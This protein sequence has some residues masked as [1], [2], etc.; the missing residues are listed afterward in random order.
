MRPR[1]A[2]VSAILAILSALPSAQAAVAANEVTPRLEN[3]HLQDCLKNDCLS[4]VGQTAFIAQGRPAL[5]AIHVQ[6][7]LQRHNSKLLKLKCD[8]F[9]YDV[10]THLL[11][12]D[13]RDVHGESLTIDHNF[14]ITKYP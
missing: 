2:L 14:I 8:S 11:M 10:V 13:N 9:R 3:F 12:C 5:S 6:L 1:L 4:A 7:E